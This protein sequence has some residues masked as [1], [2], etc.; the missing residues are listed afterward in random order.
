MAAK[1]VLCSCNDNSLHL[2]DLTSF[3]ERGKI[4]AKQEIRSIRIGPGG[5]FFSGDGSG[6]VK[7]WKLSTQ[8]TAIQ[9]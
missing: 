7:V 1:P 2:Y 5:L 3:T 9:R 8:P 6:Q 4:L